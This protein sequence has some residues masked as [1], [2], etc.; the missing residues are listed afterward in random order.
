MIE[1]SLFIVTLLYVSILV[2]YGVMQGRYAHR[3]L[4]TRPRPANPRWPSMD[5]VLPCYNEEPGI[6]ATCC[7]SLERLDYPG[8]LRFFLVDNGSSNR[9]A[10]DAIYRSYQARPRWTVI[11]QAHLGK[12]E[13]QA[14]AVRMGFGELVVTI[15]SDTVLAP[16]ALRQLVPSFAAADVG[17][18][19]GDVRVLNR[20]HNWLT[21]LLDE[22]YRLLFEQERAAQSHVG[23]VLCCSGPFSAYRRVAFEAVM[24]DY[25]GQRFL[26]LP[27]IAGDDIHL[28]NL[29]LAKGYR[30]L[31]EPSAKA[32]TIV[33]TT[34]LRYARQQAR[35]NRSFYRELVPTARAIRGR[36]PF[37][38]LDVTARLVL[39]LLLTA[40]IALAGMHA[41]EGRQAAGALSL[42][43]MGAASVGLLTRK[44]VRPTHS[45]VLRYG[46]I[47]VLLLIPV[48]FWSIA[49]VRVNG[50]GTRSLPHRSV[51]RRIDPAV[52]EATTDPVAEAITA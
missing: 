31:Y 24:D 50:W 32:Q 36:S 6:L 42:A 4:A 41:I 51:R 46:L 40:G 8:E 17:A 25:L 7:E 2:P 45:F 34:L 21:R 43:V 52:P 27:C 26:G 37:L 23:A 14:A 11:R 15:D 44:T 28:T 30:S 12:R 47:Y 16:D 49:T 9:T 48:R 38:A 13:A 39:P 3:Y 20:D 33:P 29:V 10:L 19:P 18:V 5:V 35:W 22:R 1:P